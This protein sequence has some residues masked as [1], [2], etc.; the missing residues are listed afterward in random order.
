MKGWSIAGELYQRMQCD[1]CHRA[2]ELVGFITLSRT[3]PPV[4]MQALCR[5]CAV[6]S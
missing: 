1:L 2:I 3:K 5:R 4:V 6:K